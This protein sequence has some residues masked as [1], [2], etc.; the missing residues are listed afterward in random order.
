MAQ[1][2]RC[3][4]EHHFGQVKNDHIMLDKSLFSPETNHFLRPDALQVL[5]D[6]I[7]KND[8]STK[9]KINNAR[10]NQAD[11]GYDAH[12]M[13]IPFS[14]DLFNLSNRIHKEIFEYLSAIERDVKKAVE[15]DGLFQASNMALLLST[16]GGEYQ[17]CHIDFASKNH[18]KFKK[19]VHEI[20][21]IILWPVTK[22]YLFP[23]IPILLFLSLL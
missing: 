17:S 21:Y 3:Y 8:A 23:L 18:S 7:S 11:R 15:S 12:R 22:R 6:I 4:R 16:P 1:T 9:I 10:H 19:I 13:Q 2:F 20:P 5:A 14:S